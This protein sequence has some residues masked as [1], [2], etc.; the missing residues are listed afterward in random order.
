MSVATRDEGRAVCRG[1]IDWF[2]VTLLFLLIKRDFVRASP[3]GRAPVCGAARRSM[4]F[5]LPF[6]KLRHF[7][8]LS[9]VWV[10]S[11]ARMIA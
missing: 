10:S 4:L 2:A 7:F 6:I 9:A 5:K 1:G 11:F 8:V 3:G